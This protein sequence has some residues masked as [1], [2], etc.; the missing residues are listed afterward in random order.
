MVSVPS[1]V[2][3]GPGEP[4]RRTGE[5]GAASPSDYGDRGLRPARAAELSIPRRVA[6]AHSESAESS[7][8]TVF[9]PPRQMTSDAMHRNAVARVINSHCWDGAGY[10]RLGQESRDVSGRTWNHSEG[11]NSS[12]GRHTRSDFRA[13]EATS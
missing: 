2:A 3:D 13:A 5:G 6:R 8:V 7:G 11:C 1:G 9:E 10:I 4:V 12:L